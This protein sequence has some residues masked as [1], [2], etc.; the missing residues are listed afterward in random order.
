MTAA[1]IQSADGTK[2]VTVVTDGTVERLAMDGKVQVIVNPPVPAGGTAV[3]VVNDTPLSMTGTNDA[4]HTI[5]TG[6]TFTLVSVIVG[7]EGDSTEKG[8]KVEVYYDNGTEHLI[9]REYVS[10]FTV[11]VSPNTDTTRDNVSMA[12]TGTETIIVRRT[13]LS[14]GAQEIDAIVQGY[15]I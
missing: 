11:Q 14:G 4:S 12:G 13:R 15:E 8:S 10:G 9:T 1:S 7:S 5:G 2:D 6:K 3:K